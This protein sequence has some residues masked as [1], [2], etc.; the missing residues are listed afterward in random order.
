V[1]LTSGWEIGLAQRACPVHYVVF[2]LLYHKGRCLLKAPLARR[3]E[4][5]A[6]T[7]QRL[8]V[9]GTLEQLLWLARMLLLPRQLQ[10]RE[11][12]RQYP[13]RLALGRYITLLTRSRSVRGF[14]TGAK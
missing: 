11:L 9:G 3:R 1:R 10:P 14:H 12:Q 8:D 5:L 7:W 2:D 13:L 6:E 4:V